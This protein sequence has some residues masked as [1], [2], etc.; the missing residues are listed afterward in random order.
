MSE[1]VDATGTAAAAALGF[2]SGADDAGAYNY[3]HF[4]FERDYVGR[5][6]GV[7]AGDAAVDGTVYT[8]DGDPVALSELWTDGPAVVEFGSLTCPVF[9]EKV[10]RMDALA[11]RY[12]DAVSFAVV[13]TREAHPGERHGPHTDLD[14][15]RAAARECAS[16]LGV[17]RTVLVDEVSGALHR[18]YGA[19]P[20]AVVVVGTDG[21]VSYRADW[22]DVNDLDAHIADLLAAGSAG[23][24]VA[25]TDRR[26]N[27]HR[28]TLGRARSLYRVTRRAGLDSLGDFLGSLPAMLRHRLRHRG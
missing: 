10:E 22:L 2:G 1:D 24:A 15:K 18:A 27:F 7:T 8:P 14:A 9:L 26:D 16:T 6:R 13:Y 12:G 23:G 3:R 17:E 5:D 20:N 11:E 19:L 28:P 25:P 4:D 21:T